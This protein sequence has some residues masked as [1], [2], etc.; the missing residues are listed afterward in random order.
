MEKYVFKKTNLQWVVDYDYERSECNCDAYNRGDYCRCTT[1]EHA[2]VEDTNA[3][4]VVNELYRKHS[5]TDSDIDE[6]C[7][8]RICYAFKIYDKDLYEVETGGGYYGEEVYGVYF[9]DEEKIFNTYYEM[10]ALSTDLEKIQY[11]LK[12]E[13]GYLIDCVESAAYAEIIETF[14]NNIYLPQT[15]YF[16]KV[17]REVIEEYKNR[18]LPIAV[19]VWDGNKHRLIDGY[20]RFVANN[21][22]ERVSIVVLEGDAV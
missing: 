13:Y 12:L 19:C 8:D 2:W 16:K 11:C 18:D 10:L 5:R 4:N 21:D 22:R 20:H 15:E 1:I 17:D 14:P 6:Y 3:N 7:F 9:M